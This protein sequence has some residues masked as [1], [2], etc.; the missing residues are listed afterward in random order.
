MFEEISFFRDTNSNF[1]PLTVPANAVQ[2]TSALRL[3]SVD[4]YNFL[5]PSFCLD[6][7]LFHPDMLSFE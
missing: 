5:E 2:L 1:P 3:L 4:F 7:G 6:I